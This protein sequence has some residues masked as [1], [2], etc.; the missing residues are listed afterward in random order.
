MTTCKRKLVH[1][2]LRKIVP[3]NFFKNKPINKNVLQSVTLETLNDPWLRNLLKME[4]V[5]KTLI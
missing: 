3:M 1:Y 2:V 5:I 4:K